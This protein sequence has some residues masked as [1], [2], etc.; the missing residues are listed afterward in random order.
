M[1][2]VAHQQRPCLMF[3][4]FTNILD[5]I[6]TFLFGS[7][8]SSYL[9][10]N[11]IFYFFIFFILSPKFCQ[12][13]A[14]RLIFF[15]SRVVSLVSLFHLLTASQTRASFS[16]LSFSLWS[17][18]LSVHVIRPCF[19]SSLCSVGSSSPPRHRRSGKSRKHVS[20]ASTRPQ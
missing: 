16:D 8:H 7:N 1:F 6:L 9:K 4:D 2:S 20:A 14:G 13:S 12:I 5:F 18:S 10:E 3:S 19:T 15:L 11:L 17:V